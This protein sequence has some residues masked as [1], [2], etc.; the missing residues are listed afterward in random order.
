[1]SIL[2]GKFHLDRWTIE[3]HD[4]GPD[5]PAAQHEWA[6]SFKMPGTHLLEESDDVV[7]ANLTVH[8]Q[9]I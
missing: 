7:H 8:V 1:M 9:T 4:H 3:G 2:S 5:L 6:T